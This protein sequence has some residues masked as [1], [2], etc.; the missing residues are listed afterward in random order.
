MG[1]PD[2]PEHSPRPGE[3]VACDG[4]RRVLSC[5]KYPQTGYALNQGGQCVF[6]VPLM[7]QMSLVYIL[8]KKLRDASGT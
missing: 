5:W 4:D 1:S 2:F 6:S 3:R 7:L 8:L